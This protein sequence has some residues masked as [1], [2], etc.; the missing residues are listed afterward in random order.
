MTLISGKLIA[1]LPLIPAVWDDLAQFHIIGMSLSAV[2]DS[3]YCGNSGGFNFSQPA[4]PW[5]N[6]ETYG[7]VFSNDAYTDFINF[8]VEDLPTYALPA[9]F[10]Q[11][12]DFLPIGMNDNGWLIGLNATSGQTSGRLGYIG[13]DN[14]EVWDG[15]SFRSLAFS[16]DDINN[17]GQVVGIN[18]GDLGGIA[19]FWQPG[20][21]TD[22]NGVKF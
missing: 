8:P 20:A 18:P 1:P 4:D 17:L 5:W 3:S 12:T 2:T 7:F 21:G 14:G 19:M 13:V 22:N 16:P 10:S 11:G 15:S 6:S 9:T